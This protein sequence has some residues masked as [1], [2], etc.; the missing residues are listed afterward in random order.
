MRRDNSTVFYD[1]AI[2]MFGHV[3]DTTIKMHYVDMMQQ[4]KAKSLKEQ[5]KSEIMQEL[6]YELPEIIKVEVQ[7]DAS[8]AIQQLGKDIANIL[9]R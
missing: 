8:P 3:M 2:R 9:G 1:H 7:N 6:R 5:I 4:E